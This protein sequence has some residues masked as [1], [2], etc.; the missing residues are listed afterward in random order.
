VRNTHFRAMALITLFENAIV[1]RFWLAQEWRIKRSSRLRAKRGLRLVR[2]ARDDTVWCAI[3]R[4]R[5]RA[6]ARG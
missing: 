4:P 1:S 6:R 3:A 5:K 2:A